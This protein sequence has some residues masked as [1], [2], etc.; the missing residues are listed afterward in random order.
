MERVF[1]EDFIIEG[2]KKLIKVT[3]ADNLRDFLLINNQLKV[4]DFAAGP[5]PFMDYKEVLGCYKDGFIVGSYKPLLAVISAYNYNFD[6]LAKYESD[7]VIFY[8]IV[9]DNKS[10]NQFVKDYGTAEENSK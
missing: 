10:F 8:D 9:D 3:D 6:L 1:T 4:K 2:E 7:D 5:V